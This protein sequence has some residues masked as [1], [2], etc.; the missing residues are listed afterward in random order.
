MESTEL[1]VSDLC[2]YIAR[3]QGECRSDVTANGLLGH[4]TNCGLMVC[5]FADPFNAWTEKD[6]A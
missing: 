4:V 3:L 1:T 5:P 2:N 6:E